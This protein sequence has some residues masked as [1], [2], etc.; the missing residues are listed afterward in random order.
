MYKTQYGQDFLFGQI[1]FSLPDLNMK[2]PGTVFDSDY[3]PQI[4]FMFVHRDFQGQGFGRQLLKQSLKMIKKTEHQRP[5]RLQSAFDSVGFFQKCGFV[6]V[7]EPF[8]CIHAGSRLFQTLVNMELSYPM[9]SLT[10]I[11]QS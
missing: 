3:F 5:V 11:A 6:T 8:D 10:A 2:E 1:S 9:S 4:S 7:A